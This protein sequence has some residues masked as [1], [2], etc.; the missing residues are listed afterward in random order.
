MAHSYHDELEHYDPRQIW[1]DGCEECEARGKN[2]PYSIGT[3]DS[4]RFRRAWS[5]AWQ[6]E[7]GEDV[8]PLSKAE[9]PLL[10]LFYILQVNFE[11]ECHLPMGELP[12]AVANAIY[13][14]E[15]AL[16]RSHV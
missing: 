6:F 1:H 15:E 10:N 4:G 8:G 16:G 7:N 14:C 2:V 13:D 5:R 3:M 12:N 9:I 11:R